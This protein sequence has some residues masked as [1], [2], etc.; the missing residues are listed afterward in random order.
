VG[1]SRIGGTGVHA[2][3]YTRLNL[4][5]GLQ[6]RILFRI[7]L[8]AQTPVHRR[9]S[10]KMPGACVAQRTLVGPTRSG[11]N[12]DFNRHISFFLLAVKGPRSF[13]GQSWIAA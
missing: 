10:G 9:P 3:V 4:G 6:W 7:D 5:V 13:P 11:L 8:A 1:N 12:L 2:L